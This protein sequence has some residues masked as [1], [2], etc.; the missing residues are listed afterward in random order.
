MSKLNKSKIEELPVVS[1]AEDSESLKKRQEIELAKSRVK[2]KQGRQHTL[3]RRDWIQ[4]ARGLLIA[5]GVE[6]VRI[7]RLAKMLNVTRG[8]FY[9]LFKNRDDLLSELLLDWQ[10]TNTR[11]FEKL[12]NAEHNGLNEL[13]A[14]LDT[15]ITEKDYSPD[16]DS[17]V[18]DWARRSDEA[19]RVVK[20]VD[21]HRIDLMKIIFLDLGF[22]DAEAYI[23][24]RIAYFHQVG[25]YILGLGESKAFRSSKQYLALHMKV[26]ADIQPD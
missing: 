6:H 18:R 26:L 14:L 17:A 7:G 20:R 24:A 16:Y 9:W 3:S 5:G 23:R 12:L 21:I 15:W 13:L 11:P 2:G 10:T 25:Y 22:D 8:G 4:A 19:A 1:S